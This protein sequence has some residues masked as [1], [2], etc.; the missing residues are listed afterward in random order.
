MELGLAGKR[1]L[2]TGGTSG[3]GAAISRAFAAEGARIAVNDYS[4]Q[5]AA[6]RFCK[7]LGPQAFAVIADVSDELAVARMFDVLDR[8]CGGIDILIN[9]A[10]IDGARA[11]GWEADV[12]QWMRVIEVNLKGTFLCARAAL[13]RMTA[14]RAGVIINTSSVHEVIA[15][16]GYSAY[17][18]SKAGLSMMAKTLA[19]EAAPFGVRVLCV[20]PGAIRTPINQSVWENLE[21]SRDLIEKIP[22]G[23]LGT[24][25][26]VAAMV[27][28]L[29]SDVAAYATATSVFLDGGMTDYPTFAHGG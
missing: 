13:K 25:Q 12:A 10:G 29:A 3:I 19:Q 14:A 1:V 15:W 16:T 9:N 2:V 23:R 26:E 8:R 18:A 28:V 24:P 11:V 17:V 6:E 27:T 22:I 20:A 4:D 5:E 21:M 7:E